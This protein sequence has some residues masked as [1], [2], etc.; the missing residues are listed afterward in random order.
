M[1]SRHCPVYTAPLAKVCVAPSFRGFAYL[2]PFITPA[3]RGRISS[4]TAAP[5]RPDGGL[6]RPEVEK[7]RRRTWPD[8]ASRSWDV[9]TTRRTPP[10]AAGPHSRSCSGWAGS[11]NSASFLS[12]PHASLPCAASAACQPRTSGQPIVGNAPSTQSPHSYNFRSCNTQ[13]QALV[14]FGSRPLCQSRASWP[15]EEEI[16]QHYSMPALQPERMFT[17]A[18]PVTHLQLAPK[19]GCHCKPRRGGIWMNIG[20]TGAIRCNGIEVRGP[21]GSAP[22]RST[23]P[24]QVATMAPISSNPEPPETPIVARCA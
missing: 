18:T 11:G 20:A 19:P 1:F 14:P 23:P 8:P 3:P 24:H 22:R 10:D 16:L 7:V 17:M 12:R 2:R 15:H 9:D 13:Q 6:T 4:R 21:E 5:R